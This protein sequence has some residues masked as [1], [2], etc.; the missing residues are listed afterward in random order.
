MSQPEDNENEN[1]P[2]T[3]SAEAPAACAGE[4]H[5]LITGA[6]GEYEMKKQWMRGRTIVLA[7]S[8]A[9]LAGL[10]ALLFNT[11]HVSAFTNYLTSAVGQYPGI[12]GSALNSCVLCHP[13]GGYSLNSY[14]SAY[15]AAGHSFTAIEGADSD[16]DGFS[17]IVEIRALTFPGN[18]ASFPTTAATATRR[19]GNEHGGAYSHATAGYEHGRRHGHQYTACAEHGDSHG[20]CD[21]N[22]HANTSRGD[23]DCHAH[24]HANDAGANR[25]GHEDSDAYTRPCDSNAI[26]GHK[27]GGLRRRCAEPAQQPGAARRLAC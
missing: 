7:L 21:R 8:I 5:A 16:R 20:R 3:K 24:G 4:R 9:A 6:K 13:A 23:G 2:T 26:A 19:A 25:H 1:C 14:A 10:A 27:A 22:G 18:A 11:Q 12:S 17:N 15:R